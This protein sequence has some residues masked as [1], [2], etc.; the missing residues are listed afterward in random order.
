MSLG[1]VFA[2]QEV[3]SGGELMRSLDE[4]DSG[5]ALGENHCI[6]SVA[7]GSKHSIYDMPKYKMP[8]DEMPREVA[9]RMIQDDLAFDVT[10]D[11]KYVHRESLEHYYY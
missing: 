5:V 10:P 3:I 7:T 9:Y 4:K 2:D 6:A 8:E 1:Q 11:L